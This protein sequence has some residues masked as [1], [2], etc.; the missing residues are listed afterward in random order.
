MKKS[1]YILLAACGLLAVVVLHAYTTGI[2]NPGS[3]YRTILV[4]HETHEIIPDD[5][6]ITQENAY[7]PYIPQVTNEPTTYTPLPVSESPV[8]TAPAENT[9]PE[10]ISMRFYYL[11]PILDPYVYLLPEAYLYN[12]VDFTVQAFSNEFTEAMFAYTGI[13]ILDF[14]VAD[15]K[16]YVNLHPDEAMYFDRGTTGSTDRGNRLTKTLASFPNISYFE[17]LVNGARG[18]ETSHFNFKWIGVVRNGEL[19]YLRSV[20]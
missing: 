8:L 1:S 14:W 15:D 16:L 13:Q 10:T 7:E 18:F 2:E 6:S 20:N 17:V 3:G 12:V 11:C 5:E 19:A 9:P 4:D